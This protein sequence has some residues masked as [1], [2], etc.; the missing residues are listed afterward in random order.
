LFEVEQAALHIELHAG[1][2]RHDTRG[3]KAAAHV[4]IEQQQVVDFVV[5]AQ[6]QVRFPG[7]DVVAERITFERVDLVLVGLQGL[8]LEGV[9]GVLGFDCADGDVTRRLKRFDGAVIAELDERGGVDAKNGAELDTIAEKA[10]R[11]D[12]RCREGRHVA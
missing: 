7:D 1:D 2:R 11:V 5:V 6:V 9:V 8:R 10:E 12:G 4:H 3:A